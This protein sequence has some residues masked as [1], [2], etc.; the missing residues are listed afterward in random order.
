MRRVER[1]RACSSNSPI[2]GARAASPQFSGGLPETVVFVVPNDVRRGA[3]AGCR[4]QQA[5]SLRSPEVLHPVAACS[6]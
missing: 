6:E 3:A 4:G 2:W 1:H 5:G